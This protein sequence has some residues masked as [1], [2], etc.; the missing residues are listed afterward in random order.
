M[1]DFPQKQLFKRKLEFLYDEIGD[2]GSRR[3]TLH[4]RSDGFGKGEVARRSQRGF[5]TREA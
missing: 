4:T 2:P 5:S 1:K 3:I